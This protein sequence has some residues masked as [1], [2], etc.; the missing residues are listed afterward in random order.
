[1]SET[2]QT[3]PWGTDE[4]FNPERAWNLIQNLRTE[5]DGL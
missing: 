2:P 1:M 4:E 3:P 5:K